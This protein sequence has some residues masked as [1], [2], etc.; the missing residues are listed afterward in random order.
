MTGES[1]EIVQKK[2]PRDPAATGP[3]NNITPRSDGLCAH[4]MDSGEHCRA[5]PLRGKRYCAMHDPDYQE[6]MDLARSRGGKRQIAT[7]VEGFKAGPIKDTD[8]LRKTLEKGINALIDGRL[9]PRQ[10]TALASLC[11]C[12]LKT[13]ELSDLTERLETVEDKLRD[14]GEGG[15]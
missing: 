9:H 1:E 14:R 3:D 7:P 13:L 5:A 10:A 12:L 4:I 6:I 11:N 8:Q 2:N 15:S